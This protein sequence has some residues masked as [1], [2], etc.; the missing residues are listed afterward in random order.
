MEGLDEKDLPVISVT[1]G[2]VRPRVPPIFLLLPW[3]FNY[4]SLSCFAEELS[5]IDG[6]CRAFVSLELT[7][8]LLG[9]I[10]PILLPFILLYA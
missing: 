5:S 3:P 9:I 10:L 7:F 4:V 6:L 8:Q 2:K 1:D